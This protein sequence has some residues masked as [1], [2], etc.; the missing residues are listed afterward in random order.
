MKGILTPLAT[1]IKA[2][3]IC[4]TKRKYG[5]ISILSSIT[6][7]TREMNDA[8]KMAIVTGVIGI[9]I[10]EATTTPKKR[11]IPPPLGTGFL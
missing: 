9:N 2:Q 3:I 4:I 7:T 10:R 8:I 11:G 5:E 6:P 1:I